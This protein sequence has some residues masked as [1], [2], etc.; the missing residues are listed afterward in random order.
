M[1]DLDLWSD[2]ETVSDIGLPVFQ[3]KKMIVGVKKLNSEE[4]D[5]QSM[6]SN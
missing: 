6:P 4:I 1:S 2:K 3:E 5:D